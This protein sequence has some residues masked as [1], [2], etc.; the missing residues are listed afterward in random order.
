MTDL[1]R[2]R[3]QPIQG[4]VFSMWETFLFYVSAGKIGSATHLTLEVSTG[5]DIRDAER[6]ELI[7]LFGNV[8]VDERIE[9]NQVLPTFYSTAVKFQPPVHSSF[10]YIR[11]CAS[12]LGQKSKFAHVEL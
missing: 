9:V 5:E 10:F 1:I 7:D 12:H 8:L 3:R 6:I 4:R 2:T 11:V